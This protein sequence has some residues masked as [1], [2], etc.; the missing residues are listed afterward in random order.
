LP[1]RPDL[2]ILDIIKAFDLETLDAY[3]ARSTKVQDAS[4]K[5]DA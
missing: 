4:R 3:L 2:D 1:Q 5:T